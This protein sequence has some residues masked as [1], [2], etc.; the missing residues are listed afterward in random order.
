MITSH[1]RFL[2][3]GSDSLYS[4]MSVFMISV[5]A[6]RRLQSFP[7]FLFPFPMYA[8]CG[9]FDSLSAQFDDFCL[10]LLLDG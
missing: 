2:T 5:G 7:F 4:F 8:A 3:V 1:L 6:V 9:G 10:F